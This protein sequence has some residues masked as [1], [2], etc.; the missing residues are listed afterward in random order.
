VL[1]YFSSNSSLYLTRGE[2]VCGLERAGKSTI[3]CVCVC[4]CLLVVSASVKNEMG[5]KNIPRLCIASGCVRCH[6]AAAALAANA[7]VVAAHSFLTTKNI[8]LLVPKF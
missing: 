2:C 1:F 8:R 7:A 3:V 6:A 5:S 4:V